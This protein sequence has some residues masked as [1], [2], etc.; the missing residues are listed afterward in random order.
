MKLNIFDALIFGC[1]GVTLIVLAV[2]PIKKPPQ[3]DP[4]PVPA[5]NTSDVYTNVPRPDWGKV[6]EA[7]EWSAKEIYDL[8]QRVH[9]GTTNVG[10]GTN[11]ALFASSNGVLT[12]WWSRET[13][14]KRH[15]L[16]KGPQ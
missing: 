3:P 7:Y 1:V 12:I 10:F 16:E 5:D 6:L 13:E 4:L 2:S 14:A 9:A 11:F 8:T 15:K